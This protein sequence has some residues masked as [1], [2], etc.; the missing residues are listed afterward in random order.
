[1]LPNY[2]ILLFMHA[3]PLIRQIQIRRFVLDTI[4]G[5][6]KKAQLDNVVL[7]FHTD[8]YLRS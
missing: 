6:S 8:T 7:G 1:M 5:T 3:L 4:E 2:F